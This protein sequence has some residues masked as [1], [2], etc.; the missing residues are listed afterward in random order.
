MTL[1]LAAGATAVLMMIAA[2]LSAQTP[3][4][5]AKAKASTV[6]RTADGH[7]DLQGI[8]TNATITP[9]ER[10]AAL[11]GKATLSDAEAKAYEAHRPAR[12]T[13]STSPI[14]RSSRTPVQARWA[15]TT[16]SSSIAAV[17]SPAS[18]ESSARR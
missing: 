4:A 2:P 10:P 8:W 3:A 13:R 17:S 7:P 18:T 15:R 12:P 16:T 5:K 11:T 6:P 9:M 1:G 14:R